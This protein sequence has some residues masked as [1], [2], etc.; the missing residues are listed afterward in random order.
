MYF[1]KVKIGKW[2]YS[3]MQ[4]RPWFGYRTFRNRLID[5]LYMKCVCN[6]PMRKRWHEQKQ[7]RSSERA[8]NI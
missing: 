7:W 2:C 8:T 5:M 3:K 6:Y 4:P 1:V